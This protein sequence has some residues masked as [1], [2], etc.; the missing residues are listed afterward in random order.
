MVHCFE[1]RDL[2]ICIDTPHHTQ[3]YESG[4]FRSGIWEKFLFFMVVTYVVLRVS[5]S[6]VLLIY[7][8]MMIN[9]KQ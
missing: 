8:I 6:F 5:V 9:E 4:N 3:V 2:L 7:M 1:Q